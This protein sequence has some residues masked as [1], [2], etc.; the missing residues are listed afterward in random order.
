MQRH[1]SARHVNA[2]QSRW[3]AAE[4]RASAERADGIPDRALGADIRSPIRFDLAAEGYRDV[5]VEPRIGYVSWRLLDAQTGECI[6]CAA[7]KTLLHRLADR[8]PR[9]L[10]S[11]AAM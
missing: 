11:R 8:L 7:L 6:E 1:K 4:L 3:R 5:I 9:T 2:A 10:G